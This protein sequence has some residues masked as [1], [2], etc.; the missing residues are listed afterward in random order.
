MCKKFEILNFVSS[1]KRYISPFW[2][3]YVMKWHLKLWLNEN[4]NDIQIQIGNFRIKFSNVE[5]NY[6]NWLFKIALKRHE[7]SLPIINKNCV[8]SE[9]VFWFKEL[10]K[11]SLLEQCI[12]FVGHI[13]LT[14]EFKIFKGLN[15]INKIN[16]TWIHFK[17]IK[18]L[19]IHLVD[20][21]P[22][23]HKASCVE[24]NDCKTINRKNQV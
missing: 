10:N 11:F 4:L 21:S 23:S 17:I 6:L 14:S 15:K 19:K 22:S 20:F 7:I 3:Y 2:I 13:H 9:F 24:F 12:I 5:N 8:F 18:I 1:F 16:R